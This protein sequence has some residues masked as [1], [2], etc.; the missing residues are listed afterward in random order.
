MPV[1]LEP[2]HVVP[3][4]GGVERH[5]G[6]GSCCWP[7]TGRPTW[8]WPA[9]VRWFRFGFPIRSGPLPWPDGVGWPSRGSSART[10]SSRRLRRRSRETVEPSSPFPWPCERRTTP[11]LRCY[12]QMLAVRVCVYLSHHGPN[13]GCGRSLRLTE[14][15]VEHLQDD[16][17][18]AGRAFRRVCRVRPGRVW[19]WPL[20]RLQQLRLIRW[21]A[22]GRDPMR[23]PPGRVAAGSERLAGDHRSGRVGRG[24]SAVPN[25]RPAP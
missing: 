11:A 5:G 19:S 24:G 20:S 15:V 18:G 12:D 14:V 21:A 9:L 10:A 22:D 25:F 13:G 8:W 17:A 1:G 16:A 7:R 6:R 2:Q 3:V 4:A 23:A